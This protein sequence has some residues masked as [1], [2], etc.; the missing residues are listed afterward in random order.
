[1]S[2]NNS[3]VNNDEQALEQSCNLIYRTE[4]GSYAPEN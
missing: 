4:K 3:S 1:M 2:K